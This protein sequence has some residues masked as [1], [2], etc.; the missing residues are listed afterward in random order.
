MLSVAIWFKASI[1]YFS[2]ARSKAWA[3]VHESD[4]GVPSLMGES[5]LVSRRPVVMKRQLENDQTSQMVTSSDEKKQKC[6]YDIPTIEPSSSQSQP[7][8]EAT[9]LLQ[10]CTK[11]AIKNHANR[12][13][14][15]EKAVIIGHRIRE[16]EE[17][18]PSYLPLVPGEKL[19]ELA[20]R[21]FTLGLLEHL[22]VVSLERVG[23]H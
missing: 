23:S 7:A 16:L 22:K 19:H 21:E 5:E 3:C 17:N 4:V 1:D 14:K 13:T 11:E 18:H 6:H 20:E 12:C 15:Y 10:K 8:G 9:E 2:H